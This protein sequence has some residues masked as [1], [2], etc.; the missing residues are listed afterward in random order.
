MNGL[1]RKTTDLPREKNAAAP[2]GDRI[3][4]KPSGSVSGSTCQFLAFH[5][6]FLAFLLLKTSTAARTMIT[7]IAGIMA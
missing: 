5:Y 6:N 2:L 1:F 7:A 3:E 4:S